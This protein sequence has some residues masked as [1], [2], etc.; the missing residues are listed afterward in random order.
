MKTF[1]ENLDKTLSAQE[2]EQKRQQA[3]RSSYTQKA[4]SFSERMQK[5][6]S[7]YE[8]PLKKRGF[9]FHTEG[10]V[11]YISW[12]VVFQG[13]KISLSI[14][15]TPNLA[16]G[17][18]VTFYKDNEC[19]YHKHEAIIQKNGSDQDIKTMIEESIGKLV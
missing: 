18:M 6:I 5:I 17:Y 16:C 13:K 3:E 10:I 2:L 7:E 4:I 14:E 9:T 15:N 1:L 12:S 8:G 19:L 11:P